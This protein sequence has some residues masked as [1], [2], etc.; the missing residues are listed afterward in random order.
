MSGRFHKLPVG[1]NKVDDIPHDAEQR[2]NENGVHAGDDLRA[3]QR[4]K[5]P[6]ARDADEQRP[7]R[8]LAFP[9]KGKKNRIA[10]LHRAHGEHADDYENP[11][12]R[13]R[14]RALLAKDVIAGDHI[15][16][17]ALPIAD[18][19][20][21]PREQKRESKGDGHGDATH[22]AAGVKGYNAT[23]HELGEAGY[24]TG[25]NGR[26]IRPGE[27]FRLRNALE[28][29]HLTSRR[30]PLLGGALP[31]RRRTTPRALRHVGRR[32]PLG[33]LLVETHRHLPPFRTIDEWSLPEGSR[34]SQ[35]GS[36]REGS[37][38]HVPAPFTCAL[39]AD[40]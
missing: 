10:E 21:E 29:R 33:L 23:A 35:R 27:T 3:E 5:H 28:Q 15:A 18:T 25:K 39:G 17:Q 24:H 37:W 36:L 40:P 11:D 38:A 4:H 13:T 30:S 31:L 9:A 7:T 22:L 6:H 1:G 32:L 8:D 20:H 2:Y 14:R 19:S 26:D 16:G 34:P 12:E